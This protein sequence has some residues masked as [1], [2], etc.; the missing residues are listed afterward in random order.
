MLITY[1]GH[2]GKFASLIRKNSKSD[3]QLLNF[4]YYNI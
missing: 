4:S 1:L 2:K 3:N